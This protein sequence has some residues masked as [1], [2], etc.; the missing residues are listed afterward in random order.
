MDALLGLQQAAS[1]KDS[2]RRKA[3]GKPSAGTPAT[4]PYTS[5]LPSAPF[6]VHGLAGLPS[7]PAGDSHLAS[8]PGFSAVT[9]AGFAEVPTGFPASPMGS[10]T[11]AWLGPLWHLV[12]RLP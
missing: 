4:G 7:F 2:R 10:R 9:A 8:T 6:P 5:L 12:P 11:R 3:A 1:P